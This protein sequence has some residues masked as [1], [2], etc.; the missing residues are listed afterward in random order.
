MDKKQEKVIDAI[1][2]L[3]LHVTAPDVSVKT[4]LAVQESTWFLN[5]VASE[6][7]GVLEVGSDGTIFYKF[8]PTFQTTYLLTGIRKFLATVGRGLFDVVYYLVRISF[9]IM[10][11]LSLLAIVCL[12]ALVI[13]AVFTGLKVASGDSGGG[14]D[15][16]VGDGFGIL[17]WIDFRFIADL[18]YW[19]FYG[20]AYNYNQ[21][22][23][24]VYEI[25]GK[26]SKGNFLLNC[27][28]FLFG[29][30]NP[31]RGIEDYRW[32]TI[33]TFIRHRRGVVTAEEITPYLHCDPD[34]ENSMLPVLVRFNGQPEVSETGN[35]V[36]VFPQLTSV[37]KGAERE[38][39]PFLEERQWDFSSVPVTSMLIV[40]GLSILNFAGSYWLFKHLASFHGVLQPYTWLIDI[41]LA[42]STFF[43]FFPIVRY[44]ALIVVN[45][46]IT[47]R[48]QFRAKLSNKLADPDETLT[49]KLQEAHSIRL[50]IAKTIQPAQ[51][52][53]TTER[54]ALE[55]EFDGNDLRVQ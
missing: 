12:I 46:F 49:L 15:I 9:G 37:P 44:I 34:L 52:V 18:F 4:G 40:C 51:V 8:A 27:Y 50:G 38:V 54:D 31:N 30:G 20:G 26:A 7:N 17:E 32:E 35:I 42:Y 39:P 1:R 29:D 6:T 2:S 23:T 14:G 3:N 25:Q 48:N 21:P 16:D 5:K 24:D 19:D 53:Y 47:V 36:Y 45:S 41:L 10:L 43:L 55:Q 33:A 22:K 11:I 28:S 13:I